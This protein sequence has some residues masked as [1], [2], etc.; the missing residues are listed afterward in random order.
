MSVLA[1]VDQTVRQRRTAAGQ[2]IGIKAHLIFLRPLE[3]VSEA[4]IVSIRALAPLGSKWRSD[5]LDI[6]DKITLA[7]GSSGPIVDVS[8]FVDSKTERPYFTEVMLGA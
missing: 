4:Y 3:I 8:G 2:I 7:D 5:T 1:I 6:R